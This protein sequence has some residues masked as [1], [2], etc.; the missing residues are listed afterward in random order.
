MGTYK[1]ASDPLVPQFPCQYKE[2]GTQGLPFVPQR[3]AWC[4]VWSPEVAASS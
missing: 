2:Y 4:M 1:G 3:A